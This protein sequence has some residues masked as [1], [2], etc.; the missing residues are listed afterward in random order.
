MQQSHQISTSD[1]FS[2]VY[3]NNVWGGSLGEF[4]SGKGSDNT[5]SRA[6]CEFIA[7]FVAKNSVE[8][9]KIVDL[10]CGDFRVGQQLLQKLAASEIKYQYT[11]V[12]IVPELIENHQRKYANKDINFVSLNLIEE[13]LPQGNICLIRQVLQH[14]SNQDVK[15]ILD[16]VSQYKY[17][18]ITE[19]HP[20]NKLNCIPNLDIT[21]GADIR[22]LYN[23]GV[24]LD[25]E[26]FN[27]TGVELV[28]TTPYHE[29]ACLY[30]KQSQLCTFKIENT[31][32]SQESTI[33]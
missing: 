17:V 20:V 16:K 4:Y 5:L 12:D 3:A 21:T 7:D 26:P 11:G 25:K 30:D 9:I 32:N 24:F 31:S 29:D 6:Y 23:S 2:A 27:L 15:R 22:L 8:D 18:F 19:S 33:S 14:L 10:G 1:I 13:D 28:L